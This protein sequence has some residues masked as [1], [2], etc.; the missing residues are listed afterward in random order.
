MKSPDLQGVPAYFRKGQEGE[1][2]THSLSKF[3]HSD[4]EVIWNCS[5]FTILVAFNKN[6]K[7]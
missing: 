7:G 6:D 5:T 2:T 1:R 3:A 4:T